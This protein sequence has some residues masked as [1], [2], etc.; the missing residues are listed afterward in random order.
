MERIEGVVEDII[1]RNEENG[2]TVLSVINAG[3]ET[4]VV[5]VM[6]GVTVGETIMAEG[7]YTSHNIY[8]QQ[9]KVSHIESS[10]PNEVAAIERYL[11][12]GAIK[13]I[14]PSLAEKIVDKFGPDTFYVIENDPLKLAEIKGISEKKAQA[15]G[16]VF[17]EQRTMRQ[18]VIFLQE[19]GV[20]LTYALK[21][22]G[23]YKDKTYEIIKN[24]PYLLAE[25]I[26]GISFRIADDIAEKVGVDRRSEFRLMAAVKHVL[27]KN[28][29]DGHTYLLSRLLKAQTEDLLMIGEIEFNPIFMQ[30]QIS[31]AIIIEEMEGEE[32][33]FLSSYDKMEKYIAARLFELTHVSLEKSPLTDKEIK[34]IENQ[35][36]IEFAENQVEAMSQSLSCGTLIM[37]GGP[38][39]GKTTTLNGIIQLLEDER[40]KVLLAAPTGR[41]AKRMTEATG[42][43]AK[44]IH[45]LL[46]ISGGAEGHQS[47]ARNEDYPLECDVV[48]IDEISMIDT[49]LMYHLMK[50]MVPGIRLILVGDQD[51]LPSVGPGNIL[52]DMILS[53]YIHTVKLKRIFRQAGESHIVTNA[54]KINAGKMID[55]STNNKDFF[56]I[57]RY[58]G[59]QILNEIIGLVKERLPKFAGVKQS[60]G[61]QV[62]TPTRKGILGVES[63]NSVLQKALN[64]PSKD[65]N[66]KIYRDRCFREGDKIMQIKNNYNLPWRIMS[67]Y[68]FEIDSGVGVFNGDVGVID[69]INLYTEKVR[70]I[71]DDQRMVY[72]EFSGLEELDLAYAVTIH[73]SQGSEYP[74]VVM[75]L[76]RGPVML[77]NRN[78][79][80]TG[81]TRAKNYAVLIGDQQVVKQMIENDHQT[82]RNSALNLRIQ[83]IFTLGS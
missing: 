38:G 11:S 48:I 30:L 78:L 51:Q 79:L 28:S 58:D 64:P 52:K 3:E 22:F 21:I 6:F 19:Y 60:E 76:F 5:G 46:E 50:A 42:R 29:M 37:T 47:F 31:G 59:D 57:K 70:V 66:E 55:L 61:I 1:Y 71:F 67:Q 2:Y 74:V 53:G 10:M 23:Q 62:L 65:K 63:I 4:T 26:Q 14:G 75:P 16:T 8:G 77:L 73:K 18:A 45:R 9:L 39:T 15:V 80:Y 13:G 24:N 49:N 56:F 27:M 20:S 83:E 69:E 41:A 25:D 72:Y 35:M 82:Q 17:Y 33:V 43:E 54:H 40:Q 12:S 68:G 34:N 7:T 81:L 36:G 32:R 44:T